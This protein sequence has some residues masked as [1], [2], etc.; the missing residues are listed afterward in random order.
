MQEPSYGINYYYSCTVYTPDQ[1]GMC[2]CVTSQNGYE[3][4]FQIYYYFEVNVTQ[5]CAR[6]HTIGHWA[7]LYPSYT[8]NLLNCISKIDLFVVVRSHTH[9]SVLYKYLS[10]SICMYLSIDN[11][12]YQMQIA[13][14]NDNNNTNNRVEGKKI[15]LSS[16]HK[17]IMG[18]H[19][20]ISIR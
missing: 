14:E 2:H 12:Q 11:I 5:W 7:S 18:K 8:S 16:S 3:N 17:L 6:T 20:R 1:A 13:K 19:M 9:T 15:H 10:L 4:K